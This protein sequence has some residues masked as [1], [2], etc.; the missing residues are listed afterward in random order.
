MEKKKLQ[1]DGLIMKF[2]PSPIGLVLG[3][4]ALIKF[5]DEFAFPKKKTKIAKRR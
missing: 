5:L 4:Q 3:N 1:I 2:Y